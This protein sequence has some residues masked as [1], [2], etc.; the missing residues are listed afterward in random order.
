MSL[1][2]RTGFE[3]NPVGDPM[4]PGRQRFRGINFRSLTGQDEEDRLKGIL[5]IVHI[6][7]NAP[8]NM[9]H[10]GAVPI[11]QSCKRRFISIGDESV[12]KPGVGVQVYLR[13]KD[14]SAHVAE[15]RF[16]ARSH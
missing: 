5:G 2:G 4:Q 16:V 15:Q 11:D 8:A 10:Q 12:Q 9:V 13:R 6:A 1:P 3:R 14:Q 7:Q